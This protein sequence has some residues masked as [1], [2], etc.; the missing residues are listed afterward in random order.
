MGSGPAIHLS[1]K[2][3]PNGLI[4]MSPFTS[5][6]DVARYL[7]GDLLGFLFVKERFVNKDKI[8]YAKCP[9]LI[10]HGK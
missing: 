7:V 3:N 8:K 10:I 9:L 4:L 2:Y 5:I 1:N 6:R